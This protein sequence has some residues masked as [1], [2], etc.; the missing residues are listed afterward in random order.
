MAVKKVQ[1]KKKVTVVKK[2]SVKQSASKKMATARVYTP[3]Q[4]EMIQVRAYYIWEQ[5]GRPQNQEF[6][7]W[8]RAES[9]LKK[10]K[11]LN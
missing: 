4:E 9:E 6:D 1:A 7:I 8:C 11:R 10:E 3:S 2:A 5:S